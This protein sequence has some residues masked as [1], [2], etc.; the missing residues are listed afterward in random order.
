LADSSILKSNA[1]VQRR[2]YFQESF[3]LSRRIQLF[4]VTAY[5]W[6][7]LNAQRGLEH[8]FELGFEPGLRTRASFC[9]LPVTNC[10]WSAA[11][12]PWGLLN[13]SVYESVIN[14]LTTIYILSSK[15]IA[16]SAIYTWIILSLKNQN[17]ISYSSVISA[18]FTFKQKASIAFKFNQMCLFMNN[19][20]DLIREEIGVEDISRTLIKSLGLSSYRCSTV[21]SIGC[22]GIVWSLR[23]SGVLCQRTTAHELCSQGK[24][25]FEL[26]FFTV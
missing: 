7:H 24:T 8:G 11:S 22:P 14:W 3:Q 16:Y 18:T 2:Q 13:H 19:F 1:N 25:F 6:V 12:R 26:T 10:K 20:V 4:F 5:T 17:F 23:T 9:L 21:I 15:S